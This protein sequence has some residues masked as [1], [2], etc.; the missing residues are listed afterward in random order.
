MLQSKTVNVENRNTK[1]KQNMFTVDNKDTR[2]TPMTSSGVFIATLNIFSTFS[3]I[4]TVDFD[5]IFA[6]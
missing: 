4:S 1:R 2:T 3:S 5:Q 6:V